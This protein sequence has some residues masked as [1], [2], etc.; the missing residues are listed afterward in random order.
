LK[1]EK[2]YKILLVISFLPY[3]LLILISLYHSIFGYDVYTLILPTYVKTIY[4]M[5]AFISTL[6]WN[7]LLLCFLPILPICLLYQI[8]YLTTCIINKIK[9]NKYKHISIYLI[10]ICVVLVVCVLIFIRL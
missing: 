7:A 10:A 9:H 2:I 3:V 5:E 8:I 1:K 4:G 6:S